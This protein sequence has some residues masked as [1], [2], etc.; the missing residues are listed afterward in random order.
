MLEVRTWCPKFVRPYFHVLLLYSTQI[1]YGGDSVVCSPLVA[2]FR[3][4]R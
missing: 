1:F 4:L 3:D 2:I